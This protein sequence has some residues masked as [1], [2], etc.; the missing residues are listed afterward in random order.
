MSHFDFSSYRKTSLKLQEFDRLLNAFPDLRRQYITAAEAN[1]IYTKAR[2]RYT[3]ILCLR[4][5][6]LGMLSGSAP[7]DSH[8]WVL[9]EL[10]THLDPFLHEAPTEG[11]YDQSG[12]DTSEFHILDVIDK[13]SIKKISFYYL[14]CPFVE[15]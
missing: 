2:K 12:S 10:M 6:G 5:K 9:F 4:R 7:D 15:T 8:R 1:K 3:D 11:N 13:L 14:S